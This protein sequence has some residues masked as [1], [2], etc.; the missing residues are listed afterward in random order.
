MS[1]RETILKVIDDPNLMGAYFEPRKSFSAW[2]VLKKAVFGHRLTP[3]ELKLF[4]Q[5]TGRDK[6]SGKPYREVVCRIGRRGGKTYTS[7]IIAVYLGLFFDYS[8][9]LS[10]GE[11]GVIALIAADRSQAR[12]A[13]NYINGILDNNPY[14]RNQ[15]VKQTQDRIELKTRVDIEIMTASHRTVRGRTIVCAILDEAAFFFT[16]GSTTDTEI[17]RAIMP[18]LAT[19]KNSLILIISSPY[20]QTGLLYDMDKKFY[21]VD[22]PNVLVWVA[23]SLTMN[24]ELDKGI[25]DRDMEVDRESAESEWMAAF[26]KD[27]S[28]FLSIEVIESAIITDRR[29][30]SPMKDVSYTAFCDPAGGGGRDSF[31]LAISHRDGERLILDCIRV[32]KPSFDPYAVVEEFSKVLKE[33]GCNTVTGD[34]YSGDFCSSAFQTNGIRFI[35]SSKT[36]SEIYLAVEPLFNRGRLELLDNSLLFNQLRNLERRTRQGGRDLIDHPKRSHDDV[37]NA[38]CG[39]LVNCDTSTGYFAKCSYL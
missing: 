27:L 23:D 26:R 6:P 17:Y 3:K 32:V 2:R 1:K 33:Y 22:D 31:S 29:E 11:R 9:S 35:G 39:A 14:F 12:S 34:K 19:I 21:G 4:K 38:V 13:F 16:E 15:V 28:T 20:A 7:S 18:S 8:P 25:I 30:L 24:P 5:C 36:K 10:V 37:A